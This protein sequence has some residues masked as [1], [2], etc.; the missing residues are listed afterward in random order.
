[1]AAGISDDRYGPRI[2]QYSWRSTTAA[3]TF[4]I[5]FLCLVSLLQQAFS[6]NMVIRSRGSRFR[7]VTRGTL[8]FCPWSRT[9]CSETS[10]EQLIWPGILYQ[11]K[12]ISELGPFGDSCPLCSC[13]W[14]QD[15]V[16]APLSQ[17]CSSLY[18]SVAIPTFHGCIQNQTHFKL[19]CSYRVYET[20][21]LLGLSGNFPILSRW[22]YSHSIQPSIAKSMSKSPYTAGQF[23]I[24]FPCPQVAENNSA[25]PHL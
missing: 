4:S 20:S 14:T 9:S 21:D 2:M 24:S 8:S 15:I 11:F 5:S 7:A 23:V 17:S 6:P 16:T 3:V 25:F 13:P 19:F 12:I 1:M 18:S 10:W 22:F